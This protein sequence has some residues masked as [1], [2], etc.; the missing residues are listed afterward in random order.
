VN[1]LIRNIPDDVAKVLQEQ[2]RAKGLTLAAY[3][4]LKLIELVRKD[5]TMHE[6]IKEATMKVVVLSE[7]APQSGASANARWRGSTNGTEMVTWQEEDGKFYGCMQGIHEGDW[8][9]SE[10]D[11][12]YDSREEAEAAQR[13]YYAESSRPSVEYPS[14]DE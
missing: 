1:K 11:G 7:Q 14:E 5:E 2:A 8:F 12:P 10:D 6:T 3:I 13:S 4:R 9:E